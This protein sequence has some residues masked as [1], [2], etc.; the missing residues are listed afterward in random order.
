[1][2]QTIRENPESDGS[3]RSGTNR[4]D[5]AASPARSC[6]QGS[7]NAPAMSPDPRLAAGSAA[8]GR[9]SIAGASLSS[10]Q[11]QRAGDV[12]QPAAGGRVG[13]AGAGPPPPRAA[14]A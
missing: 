8:P 9:G 1:M 2:T 13:S 14:L 11:H 7:T 12:S 10:G 4:A 6:R 5:W 3:P